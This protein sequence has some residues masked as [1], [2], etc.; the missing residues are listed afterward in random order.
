M[1]RGEQCPF[2][3]CQMSGSVQRVLS[4]IRDVHDSSLL[5]SSFIDRLHLRQCGSCKKWFLKLAQHKSKCPDR[6]M[7]PDKN[8]SHETC[9]ATDQ[10][11]TENMLDVARNLSEDHTHDRALSEVPS[12]PVDDQIS[13]KDQAWSFIRD[14]SVNDI[15]CA[16]LPPIVRGISPSLKS[17]F[18]DCCDISLTKILQDPSDDVGW[19]LFLLIPRMILCH[20]RGGISAIRQARSKFLLFLNF[21]WE[22]LLSL[23]TSSSLKHP[24]KD[25]Q[26]GLNHQKAL[27]LV[28]CGE[29]S[30]AAK[31][32]VSPGLASVSDETVL[33]LASKHPTRLKDVLCFDDSLPQPINLSESLFFAT[34]T[35]LPKCS[36]SGPSG[37]NFEHFKILASRSTTAEKFF[38]VCEQLAKGDVPK[39]VVKLLSA[40]RLIALPKLNGDV[41]PIA[42]GECIRRLTAKVL[43]LQKKESFAAY[44]SPL[45]H[46]VAIEGGSELL[47]HHLSVLAEAHP[48]WVV[49][50]TDLKNA[51]NSVERSHLLP[52][53]AKIFPDIYRHVHQMYAE[54][55][56][57]VFN[58]G[59]NA[60]LLQSQEGVHQGDPL[61][62]MLF[63]V[64]LHPYLV[65]LQESHPSTRVLAYLDD[66]FFI[67]PLDDVITC[68][69]D[70]ESSLKKIGLNIAIEKCE[71]FCNG[72]TTPPCLNRAIRVVSS[73]IDILGIPFGQ[74]QYVTES[75]L[76]IAKSGQSLCEQISSLN[77]PQSGMLLLR[78][79]HV[80]RINHMARSVCPTQLR[81]A[82]RFHDQLTKET[83]LQLVSFR[84]IENDQWLQAT[85]PVRN[86][87]F[88]MTSIETTCHIAFVSS[89]AHSLSRLPH[90]FGDLTSPIKNISCPIPSC[91][92]VGSISHQLHLALPEDK[93]LADL[94]CNTK[95]L[96]QKLNLQRTDNIVSSIL[97]NPQS[98]RSSARFRS[99]QGTGAG[100]WLDSIPQ[101]AK[102]A[103]K[104]GE[105]R[106]ATRLRLGC[107]MPLGSV[108]ST[109]EC[110]KDVDRDGYH[111]LTC[112][113]G[114]GPVWTH[115][116]LSSVWSSCLQQLK[117]TH[118]REPRN[119]YI[120]SN[121]RPDIIAFDAQSGCDIELDISVA[122]PWAQQILSQAA[123]ED[124]AAASKRELEKA[125]KYGGEW[126]MWG[127]TSNCIALVFEHFGRWGQDAVD[128]LNRLSHQSTDEDGRSNG[129][130]F[131]TYWRRCLSIALQRCNANVLCK[132][133]G[134]VVRP[135]DSTEPCFAN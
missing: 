9:Q 100:A 47:L 98:K 22:Q 59:H 45:Q 81:S 134:R 116:T 115:E 119:C 102:F 27:R 95:K 75:C 15:L 128:F 49:L 25:S 52:E 83:F 67:G 68:L 104:P 86:G 38:A 4:H 65:D 44:F 135:K 36:G 110:G 76:D 129:R 114:G 3:Y 56:P 111:L 122:H 13:C 5:P 63:S 77:D 107:E 121:D 130:E 106:L 82:A 1:S 19:K 72:L 17:L 84:N 97:A 91:T 64:A 87:G 10:D 8:T 79:C 12:V 99:L 7:K 2:P 34:L 78:Y 61:G 21:Q 73:G 37:W 41:R 120:N 24:S 131:K 125:Q 112:K 127:R 29:L 60:H 88:G 109:C 57:L 55:S 62:P 118:Q 53:V 69:D 16:Y 54:F 18:L 43:C 28:R 108:V 133:L 20:R 93:S 92:S 124:G 113:S 6:K 42:I 50:K 30:R 70:V 32:L 126:N 26:L 40:S 71:L 33:K 51:F 39:S 35:K 66:M 74:Q 58:D 132:K 90:L 23:Q 14:I 46:G 85:L 103:L 80:P 96:Q 89:W 105:F 117:M 94:M 11:L 101:S 48:D 31:L 123:L